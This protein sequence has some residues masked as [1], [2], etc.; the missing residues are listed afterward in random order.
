MLPDPVCLRAETM[1]AE[2]AEAKL[3]CLK[4]NRLLAEHHARRALG[5]ASSL[6]SHRAPKAAMTALNLIRR[7]S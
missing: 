4:G 3:Q 1:R 2:F 7:K 5:L 6:K